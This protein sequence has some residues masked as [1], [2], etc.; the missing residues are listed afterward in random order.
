MSGQKRVRLGLALV[1]GTMLVSLVAGP[2]SAATTTVRYVDDNPKSTACNHT[3]FHTIQGA[4]NASDAA[5]IVYVCPGTYHESI[6]IDVPKLLVQST[7]PR[8]A[9]IV[10]PAANNGAAVVMESAGSALKGFSIDIPSGEGFNPS[11]GAGGLADCSLVIAAVVVLNS[12]IRVI[13]NRIVATGDDTL[14]GDCGY[15]IGILAGLETVDVDVTQSPGAGA[16]AAPSFIPMPNA[17][18]RFKRNYIRDFKLA[19]ILVGGDTTARIVHNAIRYVHR[20][21]PFT[22]V[23]VNTIDATAGL[24]LPCQPFAAQGVNPLNGELGFSIGIGAGLGARV[25]IL[26]NQVFSTLD[27][28]LPEFIQVPLFMGIATLFADQGSRVSQNVVTQVYAGIAIDPF[29]EVG[30]PVVRPTGASGSSNLDVTFNRA[31]EGFYGIVVDGTN[32]YVYANRTRLNVLG[33]ISFEGSNNL[34]DENDSRFN[35]DLDCLDDTL[36]TGTAGTANTWVNNVGN[37]DVPDGICEPLDTN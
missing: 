27:F 35:W 28:D 11:V 29:L 24:T 10:P 3:S 23:P 2:A 25:D 31:N 34:F 18:L 33:L 15:L 21:D 22:C 30:P 4:I 12:N 16:N 13:S 7:K 9:H 17:N 14:S 32:N 36:G 5:D 19:G 6:V 8:M 1:L 26:Y 37:T 20:D